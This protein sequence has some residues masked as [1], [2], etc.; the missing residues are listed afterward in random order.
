MQNEEYW[1]PPQAV[2]R[3]TLLDDFDRQID[4]SIIHTGKQVGSV[5][6]GQAD[7]CILIERVVNR[8]GRYKQHP[9]DITYDAKGI[10]RVYERPAG[11]LLRDA[12]STLGLFDTNY[13]YSEHMALFLDAC[14]RMSSVYGIDLK[15]LRNPGFELDVHYADMLNDITLKVKIDTNAPW[16]KRAVMDRRWEAKSKQG[17]IAQYTADIL[18][19]YT[20]TTNIR[21]DLGYLAEARAKV[22]I[23]DV[24]EHLDELMDRK[25]GD[26][27]FEHLAGYAWAIEQGVSK[28]FHVHVAFM[29]KGSRVNADIARGFRIAGLWE[30]ITGGLGYTYVCNAHPER[31]DQDKLGIGVI[32]RSDAKSCINAINA[33]SYLAKD[34]QYLRIKPKGR[35][36]FGIGVAPDMNAKRG[37]PAQNSPTWSYVRRA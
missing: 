17:T 7:A 19:Y 15:S 37:R 25:G 6:L 3:T 2:T 13:D 24:Y 29:F 1:K 4:R 12:I 23:D 10:A 22:T 14:W 30:E 31:Y 36:A 28:G 16:F 27:V 33:N 11:G 5:T 20:K 32:R 18:Q 35:R 21:L 9:Y 34:Y 26:K 8:I